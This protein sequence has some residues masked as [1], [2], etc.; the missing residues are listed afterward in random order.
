MQRNVPILTYI[1][2]GSNLGDRDAN[3]QQAIL[4][5]NATPSVRLVR[6]SK[7]YETPAVGGPVGAPPFLNAAAEF[8]TTL[9]SH[10][11]LHRLLEI[12]QL[13]GRVRRVKWEPRPIDLDLLLYG[14]H[15]IS[16]QELVIPHPLMHERKFVLEP[17]AEIAPGMVHP[18]LQMTVG[19][20][21]AALPNR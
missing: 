12:E 19:G 4:H 9:G 8:E 16:S 20:L 2:L 15:I 11:L 13:M 5:I 10:A 21:L 6:A 18:T 17:L 7:F 3:L 14:D 1:A